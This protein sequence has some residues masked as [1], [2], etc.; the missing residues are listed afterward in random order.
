MSFRDKTSFSMV[1]SEEELHEYRI[2]RI[3]EHET[4]VLPISAVFGGNASGKSNFFKALNFAKQLVMSGRIEPNSMDVSPFKLDPK[5]ETSK[6]KFSFEVFVA[7]NLYEFDFSVLQNEITN[8]K[9]SIIRSG[10]PEILYERTKNGKFKLNPSLANR[11]YVKLISDNISRKELFLNNIIRFGQNE[12]WPVYDWFKKSLVLVLPNNQFPIRL[13]ENNGDLLDE[14]NRV[15]QRIDCG[16]TRIVRWKFQG[17]L[18]YILSA[19][20]LDYVKDY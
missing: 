19:T 13:F 15:L 8:E 16:I 4:N 7:G 2:P 17:E 9:M 12:S 11:E 6:T 14:L 10:K 20:E 18:Q 3:E 1:A 5:S